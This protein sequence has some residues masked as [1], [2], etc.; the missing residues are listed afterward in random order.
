M[1]LMS[2]GKNWRR[3]CGI[4]RVRGHSPLPFPV[5]AFR[6]KNAGDAHLLEHRLDRAEAAIQLR[7]IAQ[8]GLV[9]FGIGDD[10][11]GSLAHFEFVERAELISPSFEDAM[12]LF[13]V[14]LQQIAQE[15]QSFGSGKFGQG[16]HGRIMA[17][18]SGLLDSVK[19]IVI[20]IL[21]G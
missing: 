15:R 17:G 8:D 18:N 13:Q 19:G 5:L 6:R 21:L 10:D 3:C 20:E 12:E 2:V 7:A 11:H 4:Q 16:S 9:E 14:Q 1:T